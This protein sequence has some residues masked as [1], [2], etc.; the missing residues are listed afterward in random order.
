MH[1][2]SNKFKNS[3]ILIYGYGKSG[4]TSFKHLNKNNKV[5]IFD[6]NIKLKKSFFI[7]FNQV[8]KKEFDHILI[9]PG[10][11][12]HKCKIKYRW[13]FSTIKRI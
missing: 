11:D 9:S 1:D 12:I 7:S 4:K 13:I 8:K 2:L 3:T 6:D 10:I 5:L